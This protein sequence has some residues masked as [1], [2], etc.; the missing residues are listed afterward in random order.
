MFPFAIDIKCA[1]IF[2][3][4]VNEAIESLW[5]SRVD[6]VN[7]ATSRM[8]AKVLIHLV[9]AFRF[10]HPKIE[11][12]ICVTDFNKTRL[13]TDVLLDVITAV[14]FSIYSVSQVC[15]VFIDAVITGILP[16][17]RLNFLRFTVALI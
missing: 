14:V 9:D 10:G 13:I 2:E 17:E 16:I 11:V 1:T 6:A 5:A 12:R 7:G 4:S 3:V 8:R 15:W